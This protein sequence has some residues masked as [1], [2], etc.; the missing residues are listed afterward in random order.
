MDCATVG[1]TL[2]F[3]QSGCDSRSFSRP[4]PSLS[5]AGA[6]TRDI[7]FLPRVP[8]AI[9]G[10]GADVRHMSY[11]LRS[12]P[13]VARARTCNTR[14]LLRFPRHRW[15]GRSCAASV[16]STARHSPSEAGAQTH[17]MY[18]FFC[19]PLVFGGRGANMRRKSPSTRTLPSGARTRTRNTRLVLC[20]PR[21]RWRRHGRPAFVLLS[22]RSS[23]LV[24]RARPH[25]VCSTLC[26]PLAFGSEG[27]DARDVRFLLCAPRLRW[28]GRRWAANVSFYA[29]V[30]IQGAGAD[31]QQASS[32]ARFTP[33][34]ARARLRGVCPTLC[35][36]LAYRS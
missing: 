35:A 34:V 24:A 1:P 5:E 6:R 30:A 12:S 29:S 14:F 21:H 4:R 20:V 25:G 10:E 26:A 16:S 31:A 13:S 11:P 33:S 15:R 3:L 7:N 2:P 28:R 36:P 17:A 9:R 18:V 19:A 22:A 32:S 27:A 23:P 8:L